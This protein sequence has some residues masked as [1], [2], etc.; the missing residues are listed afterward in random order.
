MDKEWI[1]TNGL[2]GFA[3]GTVSQMLTR[4]Y[5]GYLIAAVKPPT[6]RRVFLSKLEE[7]VR[8]GQ[9]SFSLFCNQWRKESEIDCPGLKHLDRFVLGDDYCYWDYRVGEGI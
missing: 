3:S 5:H 2:G 6:E 7:T 9:E 4:R 8:I 1:L